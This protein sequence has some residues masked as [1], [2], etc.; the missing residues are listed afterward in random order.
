MAKQ[1][2][3]QSI[4]PQCLWR[5]SDVSKFLNISESTL[6]YWVHIKCIRFRKIGRL[7]RFLPQE[8][9]EDFNNQTIGKMKY[10]IGKSMKH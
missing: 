7:V 10:Q 3:E 6:R 5:T 9:I 2:T 8:I 4:I 1:H